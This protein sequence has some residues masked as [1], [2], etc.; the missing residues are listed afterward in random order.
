[1]PGSQQALVKLMK[2]Q[3]YKYFGIPTV[4]PVS[5]ATLQ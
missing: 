1:M 4:C 2:R 3:K 5:D